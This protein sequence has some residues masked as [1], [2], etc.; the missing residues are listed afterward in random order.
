MVINRQFLY[1]FWIIENVCFGVRLNFSI[2]SGVCLR[3]SHIFPK[4]DRQMWRKHEEKGK[5]YIYFIIHDLVWI[6]VD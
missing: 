3:H 6:N 1:S 2:S 4:M 5:N